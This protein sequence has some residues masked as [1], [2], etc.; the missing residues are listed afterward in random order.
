MPAVAPLPPDAIRELL[1]SQGYE[2]I[3]EDAHNW[4]FAKGQK[5][6]PVM[7]PKAVDLVPLEIAFHIA[8]RVGF[9]E[10]FEKVHEVNP[11]PEPKADSS[12]H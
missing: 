5:D 12:V 10:Y 9:N 1:E 11:G 3:E 4:A 6:E 2:I 7:V 8:R